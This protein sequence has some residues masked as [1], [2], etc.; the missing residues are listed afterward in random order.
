MKDKFLDSGKIPI[1][2]NIELL[3][4]DTYKVEG[5]GFLDEYNVES[6]FLGENLITKG[7]RIRFLISPYGELNS[8]FFG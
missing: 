7:G 8:I 2:F 5:I 6:E 4:E 3:D 1:D